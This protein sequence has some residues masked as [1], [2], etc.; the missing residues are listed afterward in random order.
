MVYGL[1]KKIDKGQSEAK[2]VSGRLIG[3]YR[4]MSVNSHKG[5]DLTKRDDIET[6]SYV[7]MFLIEGKL[8]WQGIRIDTKQGIE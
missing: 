6:L 4:Y 2:V 7:L 1:A 8:P 3:T 5:M